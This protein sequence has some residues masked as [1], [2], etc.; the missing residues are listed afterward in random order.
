MAFHGHWAINEASLYFYFGQH[1]P[2]RGIYQNANRVD[3]DDEK[4]KIRTNINTISPITREHTKREKKVDNFQFFLIPHSS[5]SQTHTIIRDA[6]CV[7]VYIYICNIWIEESY[8][9]C[10]CHTGTAHSPKAQD[11]IHDQS[12]NK[13]SGHSKWRCYSVPNQCGCVFVSVY[14]LFRIAKVICRSVCDKWM[15]TGQPLESQPDRISSA[16]HPPK[17]FFYL[18]RTMGHF[19]R[20]VL[21]IF[22]LSNHGVCQPKNEDRKASTGKKP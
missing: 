10:I 8:L 12:Q 5:Y 4:A 19:S 17:A 13:H 6:L 18:S 14:R 9:L 15:V 16:Y 22:D 20:Y 1:Y 7:V 3:D 11:A 21:V 2:A